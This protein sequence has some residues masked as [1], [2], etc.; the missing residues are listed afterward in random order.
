MPG[1]FAMYSAPANLLPTPQ[2]AREGLIDAVPLPDVLHDLR[3]GR[4][5]HLG[6]PGGVDVAEVCCDT[7]IL[8]YAVSEDEEL[9]L[10][11]VENRLVWMSRLSLVIWHVQ[12]R[13]SGT[14]AMVFEPDPTWSQSERYL[15]LA[16]DNYV[17]VFDIYS[18]EHG[19]NGWARGVLWGSRIEQEGIFPLSVV[20]PRLMVID[21]ELSRPGN[22]EVIF[23]AG[24]CH[25][26]FCRCLPRCLLRRRCF[27]LAA[28]QVSLSIVSGGVTPLVLFFSLATMPA[29]PIFGGCGVPK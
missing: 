8:L 11:H 29:L 14:I 13:W 4:D 25:R 9:F 23:T 12:D 10:C 26:F 7:I 5:V 22:G 19:W 6:L 18:F 1:P 17:Q 28:V 21:D 2:W 3:C 20:V 24:P 27:L 16:V 15:P